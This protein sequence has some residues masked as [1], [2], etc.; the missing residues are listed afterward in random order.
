[1]TKPSAAE[2]LKYIE[3]MKSI[4]S[5]SEWHTMPMDI[6]WLIRRVRTLEAALQKIASKRTLYD[7]EQTELAQKALEGDE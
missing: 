3:Q 1:M 5:Q 2:R 7:S 4:G 6:D